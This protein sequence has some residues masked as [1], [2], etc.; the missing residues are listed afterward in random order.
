MKN[1]VLR[2][3]ALTI[4]A[5]AVLA[6]AGCGTLLGLHYARGM[7]TDAAVIVGATALGLGLSGLA[8][9]VWAWVREKRG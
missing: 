9:A 3:I 1:S 4:C 2:G 5:L 8:V 6:L 7:T